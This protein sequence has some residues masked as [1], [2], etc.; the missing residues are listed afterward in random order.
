M[1]HFPPA[2][3]IYSY[4]NIIKWLREA[5]DQIGSGAEGQLRENGIAHNAM[6]AALHHAP[7]ELDEL[8]AKMNFVRVRLKG[9]SDAA[10]EVD[11]FFDVLVFDICGMSKTSA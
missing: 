8:I 9:D 4:R 5:I 10:S 7:C 2:D 3:H 6:N 1:T 11:E